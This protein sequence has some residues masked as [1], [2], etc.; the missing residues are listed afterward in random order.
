MHTQYF[1]G[2]RGGQN[3]GITFKNTVLSPGASFGGLYTLEKLPKFDS[4]DIKEFSTLSYEELTRIIFNKLGL[5][6][7]RD[8]LHEALQ[9]YQKFDDKTSPAPLYSMTPYLYVQKLY[10]GPT[11]AFK[12][13][14][15][16]PFGEIFSGFLHENKHSNDYLILVATSGDTGPATLQSFANR[17]NIKVV[18]IEINCS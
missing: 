10:C 6:V 17:P 5:N 9:L 8:L 3:L 4:D 14:A 2:T 18:C 1:T 13:M 12:D 16:Q 15:L 11:R 7:E